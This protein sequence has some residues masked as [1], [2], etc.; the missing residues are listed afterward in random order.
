[1]HFNRTGD[2]VS[3]ILEINSSANSEINA[4]RSSFCEVTEG[5]KMECDLKKSAQKVIFLCKLFDEMV[6][7]LI[8][9]IF[10]IFLS[11]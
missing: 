7:I 6:E 1:L 5:A 10:R 9:K 3:A 2:V 11:L 8:A 4:L